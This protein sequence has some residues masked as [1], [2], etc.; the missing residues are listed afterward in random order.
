MSSP[1]SEWLSPDFRQGCT[2]DCNAR[3]AHSG[4]PST[5]IDN[6][7]CNDGG[8]GVYVNAYVNAGVY[9]G[10]GRCPLGS[11]CNDCGPRVRSPPQPPSAPPSAPAPP[12]PPPVVGICNQQ[13]ASGS[14]SRS[15]WLSDG[16]CDDGGE[17]SE[18]SRCNFGG[19]C[20]D[21]GPRV[22]VLQTC[23]NTCVGARSQASPPSSLGLSPPPLTLA[24]PLSLLISPSPSLGLALPSSPSLP[25]LSLGAS[26][27]HPPLA[28]R[29]PLHPPLTSSPR[30]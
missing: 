3:D 25:S 6:E 7:V 11:D 10:H 9:R 4:A 20:D 30:I 8:P 2:N 16:R 18:Y 26:L 28:S 22:V 15:Y 13:C 23:A 24:W 21:C 14:N 12:A 1:I 27:L 29:S 5:L 17:G 19:D